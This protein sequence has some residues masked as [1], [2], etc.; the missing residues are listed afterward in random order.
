MTESRASFFGHNISFEALRLKRMPIK[1]YEKAHSD[2]NTI[3]KKNHLLLVIYN[4]L[5]GFALT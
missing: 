5:A 2:G 1:A 3:F 4:I